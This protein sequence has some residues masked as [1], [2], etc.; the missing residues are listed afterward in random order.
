M[1]WSVYALRYAHREALTRDHFITPPDPHDAPMPM[2]YFVWLLRS[3]DREILVDTGFSAATG[4]RRNRKLTRE[5][6]DALKAMGSQPDAIKDV[7]ITHLHY[8]HAG[9][10]DLFPQARFHLQD[11]EMAF[12]TGRHMCSSCMSHAFEVEDVVT[13]VRAVYAERVVYHDGDAVLAPGVSLHLAGGHTAG[14]QMVRVQT[15][16]GPIVLASDASHYYANMG[17]GRPYP[18][19][20]HL[21][22]MVE[23]WKMA[24]DLADGDPRRVIP[25]HDPAV[26]ER[27]EVLPGSNG[28]TVQ[29][30]L[31]RH[32]EEK[33]KAPA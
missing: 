9:N 24:V 11:R 25:G 19:V 15:Q 30:H 6:G 21:G 5:V 31:G 13:M 22:D 1:K 18:I 17:L 12:A 32:L 14:L 7:V 29:L 3:G 23:S 26:L 4:L 8:D 2:D 16:S 28:E 27:F 33:P 20:F 10:L